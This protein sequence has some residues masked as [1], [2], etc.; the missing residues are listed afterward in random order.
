MKEIDQE[1]F[2]KELHKRLPQNKPLYGHI[3]LTYRCNYNCIHC[4][5]KGLE[6]KE[7]E[8]TTDEWKNIIDQIQQEGCIWLTLSGGEPLAR[9]DFL[10][11]Y[12]YSKEKGLLITIFTNGSLL[13]D[14]LI[15]YFV[16]HP[17]YSIEITLNGINKNTYESV[18]RNKNSFEKIIRILHKLKDRKLP[19]SL[20][21]NGLKQNKNEKLKIKEFSE[22][23]LGKGRFKFDSIIYPSLKI[24]SD[25]SESPIQYRLSPQEM[26][27]IEESDPDMMNL[28]KEQF[29]KPA[30]LLRDQE[31][32]YQCNSWL[33]NFFINPCGRLK[34][35]QLTDK[36]SI[37]LKEISFKYGFYTFKKALLGELFKTSSKCRACSLRQICLNCPAKAFLEANEEETL[38]AYYCNLAEITQHRAHQQLINSNPMV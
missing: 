23:L 21:T 6:D 15:D 35:C 4:Y 20:K 27:D 2:I 38:V 16:N 22:E 10:E 30:H 5:C 18:T 32:L 3:D 9:E 34:F 25:S 8:L 37:D 24:Y 14:E 36:F 28:R 13:T 33:T 31:F 7:K 17:P 29:C 12:K 19:V 26:Q 1:S 11:I